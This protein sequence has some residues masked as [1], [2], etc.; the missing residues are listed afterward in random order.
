MSEDN[1]K[2]IDPIQIEDEMR[3]SYME[4]AM[5]VIVGRALPDAR[6]GLKPVHRRVLYAMH[7][8]GNLGTRPY[9]K[10]ARVVGDVIGKYHPHGDT[11]VYDATVRLAQTF[12]MRHPLVDGQ[13]NF[14]SIDGDSPAAMRYTEVR[15]TPLAHELMRD[16]D[17][18]TVAF[19]PNYDDSLQEPLVLPTRFPN[20]L[21]NG[22]TGI[23]VGMACN[24]PPHN[25]SEVLTAFLYYI[26]NRQNPS[27]DAIMRHLPGPDFP[28]GA[29]VLGKRGIREA[30]ETGR[31][32][33]TLRAIAEIENDAKRD[34]ESIVV[35]EIPY[36]VN[37]AKVVEKIA[38]LTRNKRLEGVA[39][40]R[41]ESDR[42]GMRV[43]IEVRKGFSADVLLNNLYKHTQLQ[44]SFGIILLAVLEGQPRQLSLLDAFRC[45][46]NHRV[47]VIEHRS[48]FDLKKAAVRAHVLEGLRI[49]LS[50]LDKV[51]QT[52]KTSA[53]SSDA[54][55]SLMEF[56]PLSEVQA[57]EILDMRLARLTALEQKKID[58]EYAVLQK[59]MA[60]LKTILADP[61][62]VVQVVYEE[63]KE[64]KDKNQHVRRTQLLGEQDGQFQTEDLIACEDMV[65]TISHAGFIKRISTDAYQVQHRGGK[66]KLAMASREEDFVES[67]FVASTHD[68]LL[69]FTSQGKCY[70]KMVHELPTMGRTAK[71]RAVVNLLQLDQDEAVQAYV[72][73]N[74][75]FDDNR[76]IIMA[77][78]NG[79]VN[80]TS[81]SSFSNVR[82]NGVRA[83][84]IDNADTLV[85]A[86]LTDGEQDLFFA[87]A[88]GLSLRFHENEI[89][90]IQRGGR[91]V[92]GIRLNDGDTLVFLQALS[93]EGSLLTITE[94]GYGKK[95]KLSDYRVGSRGN[96]GVFTIRTTKR[97]GKVVGVLQVQDHEQ[98]MIIT[99]TGKLIRMRLDA[100]RNMGRL[101]QGVRMIHSQENEK[102]TSIAKIMEAENLDKGIPI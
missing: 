35:T 100:L 20:L 58:D 76:H 79:V 30:Y 38:E 72:A 65:V 32:I 56:Y 75:G 87:T 1:E 92:I 2:G 73:V 27:L 45:F 37:K 29:A 24:I 19:Q 7:D 81:L 53:S 47:E 74:E 57:R 21:V 77:T 84:N 85:T 78:R 6:D 93:E 71:G 102:V 43:V 22:A 44:T 4:Y 67:M 96:K 101:T 66:G 48:R 16:L 70:S 33:L 49:A 99:Q 91:G 11:A 42:K 8:Q 83:I 64:L 60:E 34:Q 17:K 54:R 14:G 5:S 59:R 28:T 90:S 52:I 40:L 69:F 98:L 39:D 15:M 68:H 46:L 41:D 13:G 25:L 61:E 95:S 63:T 88:Q 18:E 55:T 10:S 82:K 50:N 51:I 26:Q 80:K 9:R 12:S 36:M 62:K 31:G 23:A 3:V 94:N 89:R 97:N 86:V